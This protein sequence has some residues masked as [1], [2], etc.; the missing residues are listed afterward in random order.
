MKIALIHCPIMHKVFSENLKVVDE[1]FCLAPPISLAYVAAILEKSEHEV[2]LIDAHALRLTKESTLSRLFKFKPEVLGFR[3]D[4]YQFH[5]TL[6]WIK[7]FKANMDILVIAGG[8]NLL[9]YPKETLAHREID[10]GV[11]GEAVNVLPRLLS[12]L[13]GN[14]D[15][16]NIEGIVYRNDE[17][18]RI[19]PVSIKS[20]DFNSYPFPS[21]HLLPNDKYYSFI[22]QKK[23]F[24]V[25]VTTKG[26][27]FK[28][29]FCAIKSLPYLE[30][31]PQ[32]VVD[33]I[34]ECCNK[35]M[36]KEIDFFDAVFT[37]N[38]KRTL[39]I[40]RK[41]KERSLNFEWSCRT[42]VDLVDKEL[43]VAMASSGCRQIY[44]GIESGNEGV[45]KSINKK[46]SFEQVKYIV[47]ETKKLGIRTLGFF[48]I[49][50]PKET[51][52]NLKETI[53]FMTG[54][55]LD[56]VQ[57]CKTIAKPGTDLD[58]LLIEKTGKDF[59]RE[60]VAANSSEINCSFPAPWLE[61][62]QKEQEDYVKLAYLNFYFRPSH[63]VK[64]ALKI[65]SLS[66]LMRYIR[67]SLRMLLDI[68]LGKII[69][70]DNKK[71][72]ICKC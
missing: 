54:L 3:M 68:L 35:F 30:R 45:L 33:E 67:V 22:S 57:I 7:Y 26:C 69:K 62:S 63:I 12:A 52:A 70:L 53:D 72:E 11:I 61:F 31:T 40:C 58:G 43:L 25:M 10:Y 56:F 44:Y 24:T 29:S 41:I 36:V 4:T 15:I 49:G 66:E 42:R 6:E 55:D 64:I 39:E 34:E 23:N 17:G 8:K 47:S 59:W 13:K 37:F 28:C 38:R 1:E 65:R 9:L 48:M 2:I 19:N 18:V 5:E 27:P 60:F 32:N 46:I 21:R 50:N 16:D 14:D 20:L 51:R 71:Q